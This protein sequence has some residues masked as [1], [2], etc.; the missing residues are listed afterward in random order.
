[1][2]LDS[3]TVNRS[4]VLERILILVSL[5]EPHSVGSMVILSSNHKISILV[6]SIS[7]YFSIRDGFN[8]EMAEDHLVLHIELTVMPIPALLWDY[9]LELEVAL[10][11]I[12]FK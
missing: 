6:A 2:S 12:W 8:V 5:A 9:E 7:C 10:R 1:M 3:L 11:A 4:P